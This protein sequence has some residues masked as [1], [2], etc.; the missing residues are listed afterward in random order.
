MSSKSASNLLPVKR[1]FALDAPGHRQKKEQIL[2]G[3]ALISSLVSEMS[4]LIRTTETRKWSPP[5]RLVI[6]DNRG[7]VAFSCGVQ[8]DGTVRPSGHFRKL[9]RSHFPANAFLTDGSL[10][11]H[12]FRID[13][14]AGKST[15]C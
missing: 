13:L 1:G 3:K 6:V 12:S 2:S 15:Y 5:F 10:C 7:C 14:H 8:S 4:R 11:M 9:R